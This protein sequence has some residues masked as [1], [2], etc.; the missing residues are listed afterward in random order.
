MMTQDY[1]M[2]QVEQ[3]SRALAWIL[4]LR[5][6]KRYEESL[7][8]ISETCEDLLGQPAW[9]LDLLDLPSVAQLLDDWQQLRIYAGLLELEALIQRDMGVESRAQR[10]DSRSLTLLLEAF[11]SGGRDDNNLLAAIR[12]LGRRVPIEQV[13]ACH[14]CRLTRLMRE[15]SATSR[16][17]TKLQMGL[18]H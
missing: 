16:T 5:R 15:K 12:R 2:R 8:F 3:L 11:A 7:S 17:A 18:P 9:F 10:I 4:K 14:R 6:D 1:L 13:S